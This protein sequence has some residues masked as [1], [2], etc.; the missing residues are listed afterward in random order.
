MLGVLSKMQV[1]LCRCAQTILIVLL[2]TPWVFINYEKELEGELSCYKCRL[3]YIV[4]V[5]MHLAVRMVNSTSGV[6]A[7]KKD[8]ARSTCT[9][10][11]MLATLLH[12]FWMMLV[13]RVSG[14]PVTLLM[15]ITRCLTKLLAPRN[16]LPLLQQRIG[17]TNRFKLAFSNIS[18]ASTAY[19][20]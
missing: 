12:T 5:A 9:L 2:P 18:Q 10:E 16:P 20:C 11:S 7:G 19:T 14:V 6:V 13:V 8:L 3:R 1:L 4:K 17:S 15:P